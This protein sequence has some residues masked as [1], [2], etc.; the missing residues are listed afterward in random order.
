MKPNSRF[1]SVNW[2]PRRP[3]KRC[4]FPITRARSRTSQGRRFSGATSRSFTTRT[5]G[6]P[7]T[8][9]SWVWNLC[10]PVV[11]KFVEQH[12][13]KPLLLE[14]LRQDQPWPEVAAKESKEELLAYVIEV[15]KIVATRADA[16]FIQEVLDH[17]IPALA[18][19]AEQR[20]P[21]TLLLA[22][23]DPERAEAILLAAFRAT[24]ALWRQVDSYH[25]PEALGH[26]IAPAAEDRRL[27]RPAAS[28]LQKPKA[29]IVSELF[30]R[31]DLN[32]NMRR[33]GVC[34]REPVALPTHD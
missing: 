18:F 1:S 9:L 16:P 20:T 27:R 12:S 22:S 13:L 23:L 6:S 31:Q 17:P 24:W 14:I 5:C 7:Q 34:A 30:A 26:H 32:E 25:G 19:D 11:A 33:A 8:R 21:L 15:L 10:Q 3:S 2:D 4:F 28:R 29:K